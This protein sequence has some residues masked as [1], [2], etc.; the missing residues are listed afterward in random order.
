M[1]VCVCVCFV[2]LRLFALCNDVLFCV[3]RVYVSHRLILGLI[4]KKPPAINVV[5]YLTQECVTSSKN[6]SSCLCV[7]ISHNPRNAEIIIFPNIFSVMA[8]SFVVC[9]PTVRRENLVR[10]KELQGTNTGTHAVLCKCNKYFG[11]ITHMLR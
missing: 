11:Y 9:M 5:T 7:N 2:H 10:M 4:P 8:W 6:L 1:R 3:R